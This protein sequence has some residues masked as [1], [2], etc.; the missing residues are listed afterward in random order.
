MGTDKGHLVMMQKVTEC[1]LLVMYKN[2]N[3]TQAILFIAYL[4]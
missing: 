1:T 4:I 3:M 2:V